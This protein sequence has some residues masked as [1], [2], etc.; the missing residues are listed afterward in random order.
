MTTFKALAIV[1]TLGFVSALTPSDVTLKVHPLH[2]ELSTR[3]PVF[4]FQFTHPNCT[5]LDVKSH[6]LDLKTSHSVALGFSMTGKS[7]QPGNLTLLTTP[8]E[9]RIS[10][11][12]IAGSGGRK[13]STTIEYMK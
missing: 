13:L 3:V 9:C 7:I 12:V 10:S 2:V 5:L 1:S 11:P 8:S 4:G 6:E